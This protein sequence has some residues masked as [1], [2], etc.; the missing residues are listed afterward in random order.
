MMHC[1]SGLQYRREMASGLRGLEGRPEGLLRGVRVLLALLPLLRAALLRRRL[2][3]LL[4]LLRG[5]PGPVTRCTIS[6]KAVQKAFETV[7][8]HHNGV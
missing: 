8:G 3:L 2:P 6:I 1:L 5:A 7:F 4:L